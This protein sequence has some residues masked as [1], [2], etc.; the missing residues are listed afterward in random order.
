MV[1]VLM[2]LDHST[3]V[4][5]LVQALFPPIV[6]N[7]ILQL[8]IHSKEGVKINVCGVALRMVSIQLSSGII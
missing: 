3:L 7:A 2:N 6:S 4:A 5:G 8:P 1:N